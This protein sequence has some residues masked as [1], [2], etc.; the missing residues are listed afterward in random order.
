MSETAVK[1]RGHCLNKQIV[2]SYGLIYSVDN[3][4]YVYPFDVN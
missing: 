2:H 4:F 3:N 1:P